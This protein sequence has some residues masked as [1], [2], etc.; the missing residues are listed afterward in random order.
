MCSTKCAFFGFRG[1]PQA[2]GLQCPH[3]FC[4][5]AL[6]L[7]LGFQLQTAQAIC[8]RGFRRKK[9]DPQ[10][11]PHP[12]GSMFLAWFLRGY[13]CAWPVPFGPPWALLADAVPASCPGFQPCP[14]NPE[15]RQGGPWNIRE[16]RLDGRMGWRF[17]RRFEALKVTTP[18]VWGWGLPQRAT[19]KGSLIVR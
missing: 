9:F 15:M 17:H 14:R 6:R 18:D 7:R 12:E 2:L 3:K 13:L 11:P 4:A 8:N 5:K 10:L 19:K 1:K 16:V